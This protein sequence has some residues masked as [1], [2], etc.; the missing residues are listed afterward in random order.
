MQV[1][2]LFLQLSL[3]TIRQFFLRL[4]C[5]SVS[6]WLSCS[7]CTCTECVCG[8]SMRWF[9]WWLFCIRV[10]GESVYMPEWLKNNNNNKNQVVYSF[11][12]HHFCF[13]C[14]SLSFWTYVKREKIKNNNSIN[15]SNIAFTPWHTKILRNFIRCMLHTWNI[16][17]LWMNLYAHMCMCVHVCMCVCVLCVCVPCTCV[18]ACVHMSVCACVCVCVYFV[19]VFCLCVP[20]TFVHT[21]VHMSVCACMCVCACVCMHACMCVHVCI[22]VC[23]CMPLLYFLADS[24]R[25][26][27]TPTRWLPFVFGDGRLLSR[28]RRLHSGTQQLCWN[29]HL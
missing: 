4:L 25:G 17:G 2:S 3:N 18:H 5:S 14:F 16:A 10:R 6:C 24:V 22:F 20:C 23:T 13:N 21:C 19:C 1:F 7:S 12:T 27:S 29:G 28:S 26:S 15:I 11:T 8:C 9:W